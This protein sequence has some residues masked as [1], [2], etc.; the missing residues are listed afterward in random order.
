MA[1]PSSTDQVTKILKIEV[2]SEN[3]IKNITQL[4][5]VLATVR[6]REQQ[7]TQ[8]LKQNGKQTRLTTEEVQKRKTELN[9]LKEAEKGY[10]SMIN[11]ISKAVQNE[12]KIDRTKLGSLKQLRA[13]LSN[14]TKQYDELSRVDREGL[15]G[16]QLQKDIN[17]LTK[18]IK[19]A[20][21][22]TQRFQ[23]NVGNYKS[24]LQG[25]SK[26]W[27]GFAAG[28]A[29]AARAI[30]AFAKEYKVIAD[31]EQ[32]NA[33]LST[34]LGVNKEQMEA[35]RESALH[36]GETTE[37]TASQV[38][39]L[40]TELAKLGFTQQEIINMQ[41]SVLQFATAV[42]TD[43]ASAA[44]LA[45]ATLRAFNLDS[46][47][48]ED[49]LATL[50]VATNKSALNFSMLQTSMSTIAPVANAY[51]L[52]LKD[53][54]ALLGTLANAGFDATSAATATRNILLNLAD[55][56]GKLAQTLGGSVKTFEDIMNALIKLRDSGVDLNETL[57][58]TDKRSVAA[59]NAFLSGAEASI[60][61]RE[62]LEN[63]DGEL[64]RIQS[65]RLDTVE[66][67]IKLMQSAWE[68]FIL[69]MSNSTGTIK[70]VIDAITDGITTI[71]NMLNPA[72]S[73]SE[74]ATAGMQSQLRDKYIRMLDPDEFEAYVAEQLDEYDRRI[75]KQQQ[76]VSRWGWASAFFTPFLGKYGNNKGEL[77]NLQ[78][79][80]DVFAKTAQSV[81]ENASLS[82]EQQLT[83]LENVYQR[84]VAEYQ[85]DMSL[86]QTQA[87][88]LSEQARQEYL[89]NRQSLLK[90]AYYAQ[91]AANQQEEQ[92]NQQHQKIL[93]E[94]E[95]RELE[96]RQREHKQYIDLI[97]REQ[98]KAE[99]ALINLIK[100]SQEK[101][102]AQENRNYDKQ[103][104]TIEKAMQ[105][106]A[107]K[108]GTQTKL[109]QIY[110]KQLETLEE[111]HQLNLQKLEETFA[112]ENL[113]KK[114]DIY[115]QQINLARKNSDEQFNLRRQL[116]ENQMQQELANTELTEEQK[117]LIKQKYEQEEQKLRDEQTKVVADRVTQE[118][119][120]RIMQAQ[121]AG[122][123]YEALELEMLK[124]R[125][126]NLQQYELE[127]Q[128]EF[129]A[130][131]LAAEKEYLD[132]KQ[133]LAQKEVQI[134]TAK[135]SAIGKIMG[136]LS[137]L[138]EEAGDENEAWVKTSKIL[139]LAEIAINTG[140]AIAKGISA[141]Q[142]VPYPA[143]IAAVATTIAEII[144]GITSAITTVKSAKFATG[145]KV[146]GKGTKTS[147]SIEA[148]L[149]D[150]E[151][152][153]NTDSA[154][155]YP[156]LLHEINT[157]EGGADIPHPSTLTDKERAFIESHSKEAS[158]ETSKESHGT[159]STASSKAFSEGGKVT[160][161][162]KERAFSVGGLVEN[163]FTSTELL[164]AITDIGGGIGVPV[165]NQT[166]YNNTANAYKSAT[167]ITP[168]QITEAVRNGVVGGIT[169][170]QIAEAMRQMPPQE[171][172][173]KEID[174]VNGR[175]DV[176]ENLR[177]Y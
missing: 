58:L 23:R 60:T 85:A 64:E 131:K 127:S 152:V 79:E 69:S 102:R 84:K 95:K 55:A 7:I 155:Q 47:K 87:D 169:P 111:Q 49:V 125:L 39:S 100:D 29:V 165:Q 68:G 61:L 57:E 123:D 134:E 80:R 62:E 168:E 46:T 90:E 2:D 34:I 83:Q 116:L 140:V 76:R 4:T 138:I 24:A 117:L 52:S 13:E 98:Q 130:R 163:A 32:A 3:A 6:E 150:G 37:Y 104:Q 12:L 51:G 20:E 31:F 101:R 44:A 148:L 161:T 27:L 70:S 122:E 126:D 158:I 73:V 151:V 109:Y 54:T 48:T 145:G 26:A 17:A 33:N 135:M 38:T 160:L 50:A 108:H 11:E 96:R 144:A 97:F 21:Y 25:F 113:R 110:T 112:V 132:K 103:R 82:L 175:V 35:L 174:R 88:E 16:N 124:E 142:S 22:A 137:D 1:I 78:G 119:Q 74:E 121:I 159:S 5:T 45:G 63:V 67:S 149:S 167:N 141:S 91:Q 42:G 153:V 93:S 105:E 36:L 176:I 107:A 172:A 59:F 56:S 92:Q 171:V 66:G 15:K 114:A 162:D 166:F 156:T 41:K 8:E 71:N 28:V 118:W 86:S 147:D 170:E 164:Q 128:E 143:N 129:L 40:Q 19:D 154:E 89:A 177:N 81:M 43:L 77:I 99:D 157:S 146:K 72:S 106:E 9:A 136:N 10:K 65:Q 53:T 94:Q 139:A 30:R 173:V 75:E 14:L 18:E 133:A 120:N 115:Q